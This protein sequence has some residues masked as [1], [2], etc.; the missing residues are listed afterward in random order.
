MGKSFAGFPTV[1]YIGAAY[2]IPSSQCRPS[3]VP[4]GLAPFYIDWNNYNASSTNN[5]IA[6][7]INILTGRNTPPIDVIQSVFIDNN[8]S[9]VPIYVYFPD[10]QFVASMPPNSSGWIRVLT[11]GL[12]AMICGDGFATGQIPKTYVM[13]S[14][15]NMA[16]FIDPQIQAVNPLYK[17]SPAIS[18]GN[19]IFTTGLGIPALGDQIKTISLS[20]SSLVPIIFLPIQTDG[21]YYINSMS[22]SQSNVLRNGAG[23]T[24]VDYQLYSTGASGVIF[25]AYYA[26]GNNTVNFAILYQQSGL[27]V[28]LDATEQFYV[29]IVPGTEV[30]LGTISNIFTYTYS[31]T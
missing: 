3:A 24:T 13:F 22:V 10:T 8:D 4:P 12:T 21:F 29:R 16:S 15:V 25:D 30:A 6:V 20:A 18:R 19:N 5:K 27:Q 2:G 26:A 31:K 17:A 11:N 9:L 1:P 23:T 7:A 28:K 14:N